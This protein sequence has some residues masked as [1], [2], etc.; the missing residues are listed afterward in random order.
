MSDVNSETRA[1]LLSV[2]SVG[3]RAYFVRYEV[4]V[5]HKHTRTHTEPTDISHLT[6]TRDNRHVLHKYLHHSKFYS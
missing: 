4:T 1:Q 6:K 3:S 2:P 5:Y